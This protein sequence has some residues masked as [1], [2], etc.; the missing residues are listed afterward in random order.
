M[1][2]VELVSEGTSSFKGS[3]AERVHNI[4]TAADK[5]QHVVVPPDGEFSFNQNVGDVTAAN[6]FG[7]AL[8][9]AGDRTAVGIG[10]GVCQVSTTAYRAAFWGG[11]PITQRWAHGYVVSWYGEPGMDASIFTPNVDFRFKNDTGHFILIKAAVNKAKGTIT[12]SI[13]GTK[14]GRTVEMTGPV[15]SNIQKAPPPLYRE[16]PTLK[17]GQIK[18][19]D[20]AKEGMDAVVTRIIRDGDGNVREEKIVS[21]YR[22]WQAVYLYGPGTD[23]PDQTGAAD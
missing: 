17:A 14:P 15:I 9:I 4:V 13:Y 3:P 19:V 6:G 16:D 23:V 11:F 10:G 7:D 18:Q 21:K 12:F 5:F 1:G 20:W 8:V 22:P 2:I